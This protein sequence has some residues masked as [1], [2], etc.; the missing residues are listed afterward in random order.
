MVRGS[1]PS[2]PYAT[3]SLQATKQST[4]NFNRPGGVP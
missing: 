2:D 4:L 1:G 3:V